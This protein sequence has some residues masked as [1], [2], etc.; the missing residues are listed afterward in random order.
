MLDLPPK[1]GFYP[2]FRFNK[3]SGS[4]PYLR[5]LV[6]ERHLWL[7]GG[8]GI[9]RFSECPQ[10]GRRRSIVLGRW[11]LVRRRLLL[12]RG[13]VA[14]EETAERGHRLLRRRRV[15]RRQCPLRPGSW[16]SGIGYCES[17]LVSI[18]FI[19]LYTCRRI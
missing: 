1:T 2:G 12:L 15:L 17:K 6:L 14:V 7:R 16:R 4:H 13:R 8:G 19:F 5:V 3:K 18:F 11:S 9:D 10:G